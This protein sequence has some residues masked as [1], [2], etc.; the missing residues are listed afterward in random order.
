MASSIKCPKCQ[1]WNDDSDYC[2]NCNE[3]LNY[4]IKREQEWEAKKAAQPKDKIDVYI[5][6]LKTSDKAIER[7]L[8]WAMKSVWFLV[9]GFA[10]SVILFTALGPG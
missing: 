4:Q 8:Y 1:T 7:A 6:R 5:E 10:V 2:S 3:L 9:I